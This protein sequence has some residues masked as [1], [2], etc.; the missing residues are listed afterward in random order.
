LIFGNP[1]SPG[2]R[3]TANTAKENQ[4]PLFVLIW[5]SGRP[6]PPFAAQRDF[7]DWIQANRIRVLNVAGNREGSQPG[8]RDAVRDFLV[9]ALKGM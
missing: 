4:K 8:I 2:C 1:N 6:V 3:L 9:A 5:G 7:R